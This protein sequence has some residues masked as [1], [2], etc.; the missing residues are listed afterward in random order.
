[1]RLIK[2]G[3][4]SVGRLLDV[5]CSSSPY[6]SYLLRLIPHYLSLALSQY[7]R[8][9]YKTRLRLYNLFNMTPAETLLKTAKAYLNAITKVDPNALAAVTTDSFNVTIAPASCGFGDSVT[10]EAIIQRFNALANVVV[11]LGVEIKQ[12]WVNEA[13]D[14]ITVWTAGG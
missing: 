1:M 10:R 9:P 2:E 13:A 3:R 6:S 8:L 12:T 5:S 4:M 11:E 14:Q 7:W